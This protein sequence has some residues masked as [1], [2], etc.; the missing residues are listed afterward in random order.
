QMAGFFISH[1]K[2]GGE[3]VFPLATTLNKTRRGVQCLGIYM[4]NAGLGLITQN[5]RKHST[6]HI[7]SFFK[8]TYIGVWDNLKEQ[9]E[10]NIASK[11]PCLLYNNILKLATKLKNMILKMH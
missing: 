10:D 2:F 1:A 7:I 6:A 8:K 9:N 5:V 4:V 11:T 3:C